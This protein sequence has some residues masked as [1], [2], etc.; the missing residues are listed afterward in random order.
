MRSLTSSG[1]PQRTIVK[2]STGREQMH[3]IRKGQL[4]LTG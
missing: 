2:D 4:L 3:T 1:A